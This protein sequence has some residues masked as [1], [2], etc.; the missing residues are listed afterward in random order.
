ML[1]ASSVLLLALLLYVMFANYLP[2]RQRIT[3]LESELKEVY[4]REMTLQTRLAQHEQR[5]ALREQQL[6]ALRAERD[7]LARR[8][9]DLEKQLAAA[10]QPARRR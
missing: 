2:A 7:A 9:D 10:R 3:R 1:V 5:A 6:G 4:A 8:I